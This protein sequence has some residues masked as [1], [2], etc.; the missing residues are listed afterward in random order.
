LGGVVGEVGEEGSLREPPLLPP[1]PAP[2]LP[3]LGDEGD[4][5]GS[6]GELEDEPLGELGELLGEEEGSLFIIED[7]PEGLLIESP[8][9][10][11]M[12]SP[13][14]LLIESSVLVDFFFIV[15]LFFFSAGFVVGSA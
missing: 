8:A 14:G 2:L 12:E 10:L 11:L 3:P 1:A 13:A 5:V 7:S 6:L 4:A 15:P 9:G